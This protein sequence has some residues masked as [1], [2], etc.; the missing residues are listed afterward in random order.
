MCTMS[1]YA[2]LRLL[3]VN[4]SPDKRN[5]YVVELPKFDGAA[6]APRS[7]PRRYS[8]PCRHAL[9][10]LTSNATNDEQSQMIRILT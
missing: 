2:G 5:R 8:A 3:T 10:A 6:I 9:K 1:V 7:G 4:I